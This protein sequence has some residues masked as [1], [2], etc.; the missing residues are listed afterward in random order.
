MKNVNDSEWPTRPFAVVSSAS[1]SFGFAAC[2]QAA[3]FCLKG[4]LLNIARL[5][6][7]AENPSRKRAYVFCSS[8]LERLGLDQE[9]PVLKSAPEHKSYTSL[10]SKM[11]KL[12]SLIEK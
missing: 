4:N 6:W 9:C 7:A 12:A 10:L 1:S 2:F 11:T 5:I 8:G 3:F